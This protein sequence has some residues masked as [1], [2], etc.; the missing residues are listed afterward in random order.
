MALLAKPE[1]APAPVAHH[2]FVSEAPPS[3]GDPFTV[4]VPEFDQAGGHV[5]QIRRWVSRGKTVPAVGDE[6]L[7]VVDDIA[8][9]WAAAW[10][11]AAG[12]API[13]GGGGSGVDSF[14][15]GG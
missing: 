5:F 3:L 14:F 10:W 12:D 1:S 6:V 9:P 7:V 13:E 8:E 2:G 11:P 4:T 15:L